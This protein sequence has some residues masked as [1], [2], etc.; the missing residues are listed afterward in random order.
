MA[1]EV[2]AIIHVPSTKRRFRK[3]RG[4]SISE[5]KEAGLSFQEAKRLGIPVDRRRRSAWEENI[6]TLKMSYVTGVDL[7]EVKGIGRAV[8]ERLIAAGIL[9]AYDLAKADVKELAKKVNYSLSRLERWKQE[10][11]KLLKNR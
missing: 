8:A 11:E 7:T 3:G 6:R 1:G 4:F 2:K 9:D 10:A 5:I